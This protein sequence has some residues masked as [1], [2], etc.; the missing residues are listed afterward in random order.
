MCEAADDPSPARKQ[1]CP[2]TSV[3]PEAKFPAGTGLRDI[4]VDNKRNCHIF[5]CFQRLIT[6]SSSNIGTAVMSSEMLGE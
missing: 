5:A 4:Q 2:S 1:I 3:P 6:I